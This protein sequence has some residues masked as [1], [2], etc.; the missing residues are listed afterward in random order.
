MGV[1]GHFSKGVT[2][3]CQ[4]TEVRMLHGSARVWNRGFFCVW[5]R[6]NTENKLD[7]IHITLKA[8]ILMPGTPCHLGRGFVCRLSLLFSFRQ[9]ESYWTHLQ[10]SVVYILQL[11]VFFQ[12][13][14]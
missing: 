13:G 6:Q 4:D 10:C 9:L 11:C 14:L 2:W 8:Q 12:S 3:E 7:K 5:E 1:P